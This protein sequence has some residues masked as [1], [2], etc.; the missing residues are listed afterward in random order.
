M[1]THYSAALLTFVVAVLKIEFCLCRFLS[2]FCFVVLRI[3]TLLLSYLRQP[4]YFDV[5]FVV[6]KQNLRKPRL[7][8]E[9]SV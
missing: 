7:A 2:S 8:V 1:I 4:F 5:F 3:L 6:L 9:L